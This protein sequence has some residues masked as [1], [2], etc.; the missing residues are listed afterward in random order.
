MATSRIIPGGSL[1]I[2][3][4]KPRKQPCANSGGWAYFWGGI[5]RRAGFFYVIE[6][7]PHP[8]HPPH[9]VSYEWPAER[10]KLS[11]A[12]MSDVLD[13]C[14]CCVE[15]ASHYGVP[16][17]KVPVSWKGSVPKKPFHEMIL[18]KLTPEE[19]SLLDR[20]L[21]GVPDYKA[22]NI[23]DAVGVGLYANGRKIL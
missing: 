4:V 5:L 15:V 14:W 9:K 16:A 18:A 19:R 20:Q 10:G 8:V 3:P 22:D 6:D 1:A 17:V 7:L 12:R 13:L 2:D 21:I 11:T 23:K